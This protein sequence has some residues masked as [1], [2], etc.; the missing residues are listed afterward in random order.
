MLATVDANVLVALFAF[1]TAIVTVAIPQ[2]RA[3]RRSEKHQREIKDALGEKNGNGNAMEMLAKSMAAAYELLG[4]MD[5]HEELDTTR[6]QALD[7]AVEQ[8]SGQ[9]ATAT[10]AAASAA[11]AAASTASSAAVLAAGVAERL[12]AKEDGDKTP[13]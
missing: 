3:N 6:F 8:V 13:D 9:V 5:R 1:L 11:Q 12:K 2:I 4:R 10:S 7:E